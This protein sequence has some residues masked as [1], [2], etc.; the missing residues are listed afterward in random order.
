MLTPQQALNVIPNH[1]KNIHLIAVCGTAMGALACMLKDK[2]YVV[3]GSDISIYPPMSDFL[4]NIGIEILEGFAPEHIPADCELVVVGNAVSVGNAECQEMIR[5]DLCYCS[6][7]QALNLLVAPDKQVLMVAGTHGKT[8]TSSLLAWL[9]ESAGLQPSFFIGGILKNFARNYQLGAGPYIV[10]EGDEYDTAFFD[11]KSKF[12]HFDP[13]RLILTSVEFDHAD[14]FADFAAV[15]AAFSELMAKLGSDCLV[16]GGE[17]P[18]LDDLLPETRARVLRYGVQAQADWR[19]GAFSFSGGLAH[20]E[21]W[22]Q[23]KLWYNFHAPLVGEHNLTNVLACI[24]VAESLGLSREQIAHGLLSFA[25]VKRRQEVR[26]TKNGVIVL[27]DFAH[28]PTAVKATVQAVRAFY[29]AK[30]LVAVF[31]P[32]SNTSMRSVFQAEYAG[33]FDAADLTVISDVPLKHKVPPGQLFSVKQLV[34]DL[35]SRGLDAHLFPGAAAIV[36]FL[37][38]QLESDTVVLVMSNGGFDNI[39]QCLLDA[40]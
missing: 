40:L 12:F 38:A 35:R 19:L 2:G 29:P 37:K 18:A 30:R 7:P 25:G 17:G 20:F 9:L 24:A 34:S 10:V 26:G 13:A 39:H 6:M 1:V 23:G 3:S 5:R 28:H 15:R 27:D 33:A 4:Q 36:A 21:V 11:K 14:I 31:E 32:R 8:T 22:H 16:L